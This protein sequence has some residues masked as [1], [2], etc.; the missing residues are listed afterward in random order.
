MPAPSS[1]QSRRPGRGS[2]GN[3]AALGAPA[4]PVVAVAT[5][6]SCLALLDGASGAFV[7]GSEALVEFLVQRARHYIYSTAPPAALA[8]AA[9][10]PQ[11]K[12]SPAPP[13]GL[14]SIDVHGGRQPDLELAVAVAG[15]NHLAR[16]LTTLPPNELDCV[17]YRRALQRLAR[18]EGWSF[19]FYDERALARL[20]AGAFLAVTRANAHRGAGIVRL[21]YRPARSSR[22]RRVGL[23]GKGICFD[24]GGINLK[25]HK[26]MYLM[27]GDMQGSAVA[28]GSVVVAFVP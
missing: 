23:V 1:S 11:R 9:P 26:G 22:T 15:G 2:A 6:D 24:T 16:W 5:E 27:H 25:A 17:A 4:A 18:R 3:S 13:A 12:S 28:V 8:A 14:R 10:M 21:S 19:R 20:G 7:A